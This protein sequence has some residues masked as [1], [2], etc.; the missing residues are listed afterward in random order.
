MLEFTDQAIMINCVES[1]WMINKNSNNSIIFVKIRTEFF[2]K[3]SIIA[4]DI[5]TLGDRA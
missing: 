4:Y 1:F 5:P 3:G 2:K